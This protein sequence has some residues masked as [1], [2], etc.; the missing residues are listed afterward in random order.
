[1]DLPQEYAHTQV[2]M[3]LRLAE[4]FGWNALE[5]MLHLTMPMVRLLEE[6]E[7]LRQ[8]E[9]TRLELAKLGVQVG[10][11]TDTRRG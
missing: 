6:Y 10:V 1:M 9:E 5:G 7:H 11:R 4:R 2:Y 8:R 3:H